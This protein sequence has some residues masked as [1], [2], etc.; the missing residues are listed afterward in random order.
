MEVDSTSFITHSFMKWKG[1]INVLFID[2]ADFN[3]LLSVP[4]NST[5]PRI[6]AIQA[7]YTIYSI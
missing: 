3:P 5:C 2:G 7:G 1:N 4:I 6:Q